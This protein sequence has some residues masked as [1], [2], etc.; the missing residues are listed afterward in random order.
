[1]QLSFSQLSS[2]DTC[3]RQYEFAYIKKLPR[4]ISAGESFGSSVHNTLKKW[5]DIEIGG[6]E[7][8]VGNRQNSFSQTSLFSDD[9]ETAQSQVLLP[10]PNTLHSFWHQSFIVEGYAT[11]ADADVARK[12]GERLM[13]GFFDWWKK[14][15]REVIAVEKG[16]SLSLSSDSSASSDSFVSSDSSA[17]F[18]L[19]GRF[20]RIERCGDG[21]RIID[22]KTGA[23]RD[24][25]SVDSDLQLSIYVL[26]AEEM[27]GL[28]CVGLSFLF[29]RDEGITEVTTVRT[30]KQLEEARARLNGMTREILQANFAPTP[31]AAACSRCPYRNV[32][33]AAIK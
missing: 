16:F 30:P 5:G 18:I 13:E 10:T 23:V 3:P 12:R 2:Y 11:K 29:L 19:S 33:D 26:A 20:D 28:P 9:Q 6:R 17:S 32:C 24:Q 7:S 1:M 14:E 4:Q 8:G 31:S 21:L 27:F 25:K 15:R 22:F